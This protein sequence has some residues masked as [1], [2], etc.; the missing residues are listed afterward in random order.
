MKPKNHVQNFGFEMVPKCATSKNDDDIERL[1]YVH[2]NW[3]EDR[4]ADY[5]SDYII[6]IRIWNIQNVYIVNL[7]G[8]LA[9]III[10]IIL[11]GSNILNIELNVS[12]GHTET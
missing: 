1:K 3:T 11:W 4:L 9:E 6:S 7:R 12:S 8:W 10:E 2:N 5:C